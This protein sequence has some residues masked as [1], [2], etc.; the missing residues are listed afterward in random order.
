MK[1]FNIALLFFLTAAAVAGDIVMPVLY[2]H[3]GDQ[4]MGLQNT[5]SAFRGAWQNNCRGVELD[6]RQTKDGKLICFHDADFS[7]LAGDKRKVANLTYDEIKKIDISCFK[8]PMF[9]DEHPPLLEE[10]FAEMP[11]G[12]NLHIEVKANSVDCDFPQRLRELMQ[13]YRVDSEQITVVSFDEDVLRNL[14]RKTPGIQN[15]WIV[16][17]RCCRNLGMGKGDDIT[18]VE[19]KLI[20][21][22]KDIGCT[23]VSFAAGDSRIKFDRRFTD[24]LKKSGLQYSFWL[25]NDLWQLRRLAEYGAETVLSDRPVSLQYAWEKRFGKK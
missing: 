17:L 14:N 21:K 1:F 20:A 12:F 6:V 15:M 25:V 4:E 8:H 7:K 9:K 19:D 10:V 2:G 22:L 5:M 24:K 3:R 13:K 11:K 16:G 18:K 23:G